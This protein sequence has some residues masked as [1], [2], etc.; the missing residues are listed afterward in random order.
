MYRICV[1]HVLRQMIY[2]TRSE[3]ILA[4]KYGREWVDAKRRQLEAQDTIW[5]TRI[6]EEYA[7]AAG[8]ELT[9]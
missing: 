2:H 4:L 9:E 8:I 6:R 1:G 7:A 5:K 3:H